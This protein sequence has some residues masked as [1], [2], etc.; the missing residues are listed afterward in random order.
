MKPGRTPVPTFWFRGGWRLAAG[1]ALLPFGGAPLA[2]ATAH[3]LILHT[4]DVHDHVR[5]GDAGVGGL[6][7]VSGYIK[8]V[9]AGRSDVLLLDAG[10]VTEKG[11]L[12]AFRTH[13]D[14]TYEAMRRIGYN[15]ITIGNHEFD[16][17]GIAGMHHYEAVLGQP[18]LCLNI[19]DKAGAPAFEAGRIVEVNGIKVGLI[20]LIVPRSAGCLD[21]AASGR[22]LAAEAATLHQQGAV[23][24]VAVCHEGSKKC[25][26]WSRAAPGVAVFVSGH[27]HEELLAPVTVP[28][29]GALIVQAGSY[30]RW[31]GR[32]E[33]EVDTVT[34]KILHADGRLVPMRHDQVPVDAEML[35]WVRA[36]EQAL[37]PEAAT[38]VFNNPAPLDGYAIARLAAEGLRRA[39]G[40]DIGFCHP[41]QVIRDTL[42]AGPADVNALFRTGGHRG[43]ETVL[44]DLTGAEVESYLNALQTIQR[45]PPEWVGFKVRRVAGP[46]SGEILR[47]DLDPVRHYR[48]VM[49]KIEWETR[50]LRLAAKVRAR[51]PVHAPAARD[52]VPVPASAT[53]TDALQACIKQ[54]LAA[55]D[56]VQDRAMQLARQRELAP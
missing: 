47:T 1:L 4:N 53:F 32:L 12:V 33:L 2:A 36:Q 11:D 27:T 56:T 25:A 5:A 16:A 38:F 19:L 6:P 28:E 8:Q 23:L 30:A 18:M 10:D 35:A 40:A 17:V 54:T 20:G 3:L 21:A 39:A 43:S 55:G 48:V 31:V 9:R 44:V 46:G 22:A 51:D 29:T 50:Y 41:A 24:V 13:S 34:G 14:L 37:A 15:G 49:P 52:I 7:Y 45:E 26:D 42:P